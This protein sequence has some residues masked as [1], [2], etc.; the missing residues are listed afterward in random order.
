MANKCTRFDVKV[1]VY[2]T[3]PLSEM[4]PCEIES[5]FLC[6]A[7]LLRIKQNCG[8]AVR[9]LRRG[10][11]EGRN[12]NHNSNGDDEEEEL[13]FRGLEHMRSQAH[14]EQRRI[15]RDCNVQAVLF[16]QQKQWHQKPPSSAED[17]DEAVAEASRT[18]SKWARDL[19][20]ANGMADAAFV[21]MDRMKQIRSAAAPRQGSALKRAWDQLHQDSL[22]ERECVLPTLANFNDPA[23]VQALNK[24]QM[25]L[26]QL[27]EGVAHLM[28][29]L[30]SSSVEAK[31]SPSKATQ[32][33]NMT[34]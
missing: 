13:C 21:R 2:S 1:E 15:N 18:T 6:N 3:I 12:R 17:M 22:L 24:R 7:D 29:V 34:W 8:R 25:Q 32:Y 31:A 28:K 19:A 9:A 16:E 4:T 20:T 27:R 14:L 11:A 5:S 30:P 23:R 33:E 26:C 10:E